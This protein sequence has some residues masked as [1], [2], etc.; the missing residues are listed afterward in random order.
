M[1]LRRAVDKVPAPGWTK[2]MGFEDS[3]VWVGPNGQQ[4]EAPPEMLVVVEWDDDNPTR[5]RRAQADGQG[6]PVGE[7]TPWS[8]PVA[9]G[10]NGGFFSETFGGTID[11]ARDFVTSPEFA[12]VAGG[13]MAGNYALTGS[14]F[15]G[16]G[17]GARYMAQ[18]PGGGAGSLSYSVDAASPS[19]LT[20][21]GG[22]PDAIAEIDNLIRQTGASTANEAAQKV[23]YQSIEAYLGAVNPEYLS[24]AGAGALAG[25]AAA[26]GAGWTG[27][28][29]A[30]GGVGA[31]ASV[32]GLLTAG[33]ALLGAA[34]GSAK[35][36]GSTTT[37]SS[38]ELPSWQLPYVQAG[39]KDAA[40]I[41]A[42]MPKGQ[43]DPLTQKAYDYTQAVIRGD[44]L[45]SNPSDATYRAMTNYENPNEALLRPTAEG[46][47]LKGNPYLDEIWKG[48]SAR[49]TDA[50]S[51]GT[52]AQTDA[53]FS[54][55][56]AYGGTGYQEQVRNNQRALG[57]SLALGSA[58]LYGANYDAER[59][60]QLGAANSLLASS[61]ATQGIRATGAGGLTANYNAERGR[62]QQA[63]TT[64]PDFSKA[65]LEQP[66]A[67]TNAY[68][69]AVGRQFGEQG[70][71]TQP[72]FE[73]RLG[74]A[75]GGALAGYGLSR[76][77]A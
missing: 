8:N 39:L 49:I 4:A 57:D 5:S 50:Y 48:N 34:G 42:G 61:N 46:A 55:A 70:S 28:A 2:Q 22:R 52:A 21:S 19:G 72:Y 13:G 17:E 1:N 64:A 20:A 3:F 67:S 68:L 9:R 29:K 10:G 58:N 53:A 32:P 56:G 47:Y 43:V 14:A 77:F 26:S 24:A 44:F 60:R 40:Q 11:G 30:A 69:Q 31:L 66:L 33:G 27:A 54:R 36:A 37:T 15:P 45:D 51:R 62:Q 63:A 38:T 7:W 23:G 16:A 25:G 18:A 75:M 6:N 65:F 74:G 12:L 71:Q 59:T 35:P 41:Y 76:A 73:N